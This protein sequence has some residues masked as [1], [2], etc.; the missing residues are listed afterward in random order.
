MSD[1]DD[2][3]Y[4]GYLATVGINTAEQGYFNNETSLYQFEQLFQ[5][6]SFKEEY[7]SHDIEVVVD[8]ARIH[9]ARKYIINRFGEGIATNYPAPA[10]EYL[11]REGHT[12]SVSYY[13]EKDEHRG[14]SNGLLKLAKDL[15]VYPSF[16]QASRTSLASRKLPS[17]SKHLK[18]IKTS[19]YNTKLIFVPKFHCKLNAIEGET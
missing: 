18:A 4:D 6:L 5:V 17:V 15:S 13:S 16:N 1:S 2:L 19:K 7:K 12:T 14:K 3:N 10:L 9:S 8:N 11:D